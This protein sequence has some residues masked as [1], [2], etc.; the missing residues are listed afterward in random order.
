[1]HTVFGILIAGGI[2]YYFN[3][4]E[5]SLVS[6]LE[7]TAAPE[8]IILEAFK[9]GKDFST[10]KNRVESAFNYRTILHQNL[11]MILSPEE[12]DQYAII[13]GENGGGKST[14]V[15]KVL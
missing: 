1:M 10:Y 6:I 5:R 12:S 3:K 2:G 7:P 4:S 11:K 9:N 8:F 15:R 13:V 14:A